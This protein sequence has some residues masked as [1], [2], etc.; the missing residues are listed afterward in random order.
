[1]KKIYT[2]GLAMSV[3]LG[4]PMASSQTLLGVYYGNQGW[5]MDDVTNLESWQGKKNA[6]VNLYTNWTESSESLL[7]TYQLPYVWDHGNIPMITWEPYLAPTTPNDIETRI[8]QG[9]YDTYVERWGGK[10]RQF[11]AGTDGV[12]GT[13]DDRRVYIRLAHEANG[14]WYPWSAQDGVNTPAD[15]VAMWQRVYQ[16]LA[17]QGLDKAHVQWIWSI[18]NA[19]AGA[20]KAEAYYPGDAYVDWVGLDGYNWGSTYSWSNWQTPTQV[21]GYIRE[22]VAAL[23]PTKPIAITEVAST[24]TT[25]NGVNTAAKDAWITQFGSY[26]KDNDIRMVTW[27]NEEKETNWQIFAG[28]YGTTQA[29]GFN[30]YPAYQS[31]VQDAVVIAADETNPRI[32]SDSQFQ[33]NLSSSQPVVAKT[34]QVSYTIGSRWTG[35]YVAGVHVAA[36]YTIPRN[37]KLT[38]TYANGEKASSWWNAE[39][40]QTSTQVV[41][42]PPSWWQW[43]PYGAEPDFG[44]VS[45]GL[46]A[47]PTQANLNGIPCNVTLK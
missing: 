27:F 33:G 35:G 29:N 17:A 41:A 38:W 5:A 26:V 21:F 10:L 2:A 25:T 13:A 42:T 1:M 40:Q 19:D 45:S 23:A 9:N 30:V 37:W 36:N 32:L 15:Y 43:M 34:C 46:P 44:L 28:Q 31:L 39:L 12:Y 16:H 18:N 22:R 3:L 7:F 11:L 24:A 14:D 8:A 4:S 20:F 6:I 47:A